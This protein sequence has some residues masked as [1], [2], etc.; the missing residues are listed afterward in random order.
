MAGW[1]ILRSE[2]FLGI[3]RKEKQSTLKNENLAIGI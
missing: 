2:R 3:L 1:G